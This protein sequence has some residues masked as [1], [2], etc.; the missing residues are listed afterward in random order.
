[1]D[2]YITRA[3]FEAFKK[4][5]RQQRQT[6]E[7]KAINVNVASQ[8]VL[9]RL[10]ELKQDLTQE[11]TTVSETWLETMQENYGEHKADF[12]LLRESQADFRDTLLE[13]KRTM[14][15]KDDIA[16]IMATQEQILQ[17]LQQKPGE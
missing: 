12:L 1:M 11:L 7:M 17:L 13:V 2:E 5:L 14:A 4:E 16:E 6:D 9:N 8:D 10:D 15:T 3:E